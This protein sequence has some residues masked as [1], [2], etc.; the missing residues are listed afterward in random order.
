MSKSFFNILVYNTRSILSIDKRFIFSNTIFYRQAYDIICLTE[1]WLTNDVPDGALFLNGYSL[2]RSERPAKANG[3]SS[4]GGVLIAIRNSISF[5]QIPLNLPDYM[6]SELIAMACIIGTLKIMLVAVYC[7]PVNSPYRWPEVSMTTIFPQLE[8]LRAANNCDDIVI[9]GDL[10]LAATDW[11][12]QHSNDEYESQLLN[13]IDDL[14]YRQ[15][16]T[17]PTTHSGSLLDVV[18]CKNGD[19]IVNVVA[20][21]LLDK[22][23]SQGGNPFSDHVPITFMVDRGFVPNVKQPTESFLSYT[24]ADY[25]QLSDLIAN[26][27]FLPSCWSNANIV[28]EAWYNWINA[29]LLKSVPKRTRHRQ[30]Q[31]PWIT[32]GTSHLI[33]TLNTRKKA[34]KRLPNPSQ[35]K[36]GRLEELESTVQNAIATDQ[37]AYEA[38]IFGSGRFDK[39]QKYFK[40][41]RKSSD[42]PTSVF[43]NSTSADTDKDKADLFNSFFQSV[44]TTGITTE[45]PLIEIPD[46]EILT[47]FEITASSVFEVLK[48]LNP[49]KARGS[50]NIPPALLKRMAN[51]LAPSLSIVLNQCKYYSIFPSRWKRSIVKP[52]FKSGDKRN[53]E[54]YRPIQ[55][56][57][58]PSK[59]FERL[60]LNA[61]YGHV[62]EK[63]VSCQYGFTKKR[64]AVTQMLLFVDK[65]YRGLDDKDNEVE[66]L[67]LDFCKA[68]DKVSHKLL[69]RKLWNL[70]L[71]G[72]LYKLLKSY[73]SNRFQSVKVGSSVSGFLAVLSGVPQGSLLGPLLFLIFINDMVDRV[74][75][76]EIFLFADDGKLLSIGDKESAA[77][78]E[79]W[80]D[81]LALGAWADQNSMEFSSEKSSQLTFRGEGIELQLND[82]KLNQKNA[83]KDLGVIVDHRLSWTQNVVLRCQ[84]ATRA[85]YAI[86]RSCSPLLCEADKLKVYKSFVVPIATYASAVWFPSKGNMKLIEQLQ[87]RATRWITD[88]DLDYKRRLLRLNLLP[89][90]LYLQMHD[91]LLFVKIVTGHYDIPWESCI[92]YAPTISTRSSDSP[93]FYVPRTNYV[94]TSENFW[95]RTAKT[96]NKLPPG[97]D[98]LNIIGLKRRLSKLFWDYFSLHYQENCTCSWVLVCQCSESCR[99]TRFPTLT[100]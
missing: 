100:T 54:K 78:R 3:N 43:W 49:T 11:S 29:H 32:P 8:S 20:D 94:K 58:C 53:V 65:L 15:I 91:I 93:L 57:D 44:F 26:F 74:E 76:N 88:P 52:L 60:I 40:S 38:E 99:N 7:A 83:E 72:K 56:L 23:L 27:P 59:V 63:L 89:L 79:I 9:C 73:L 71:R 98:V 45:I 87:H 77:R 86:K 16:I 85:L 80:S 90:S 6:S 47:D 55:L 64:S 2:L 30:C 81:L 75:F 21:Q 66:V 22:I 1:T 18:I 51:S 39:L 14:N 68:F 17:F 24:N 12:C 41:L 37:A 82:F 13:A 67:Y 96:V 61:I 46:D 36:L 10:N 50:D 42:I 62:R 69:L 28:V 97:I 35:H 33:K 70:G 34:T 95:H 5:Y 84:K 48:S 25:E 92:S 31:P 19:S 4:H